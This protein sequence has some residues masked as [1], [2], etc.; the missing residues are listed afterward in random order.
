MTI[1]LAVP[2]DEEDPVTKHPFT[3]DEFKAIYARVP[4]VCVDLVFL[5]PQSETHTNRVLLTKRS[6][7]PKVWHLPGGT[8]QHGESIDAAACRVAARELGITIVRG[9][10]M[11]VLEYP[12]HR[13]H[14]DSPIGLAYMVGGLPPDTKITL[15]DEASEY[16]WTACIPEDTHADQWTFI[17]TL[18]QG[19]RPLKHS[20]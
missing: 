9:N 20:W 13:L 16:L 11:G 1:T 3:H 8:I 18:M 4:R 5:R 14:G 12:S 7:D 19:H 15:N 6:I 10:V 2:Y 17:H